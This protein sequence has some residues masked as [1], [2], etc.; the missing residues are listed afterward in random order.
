MVAI[1]SEWWLVPITADHCGHIPG[2]LVTMVHPCYT[3]YYGVA[4][5]HMMLSTQYLK[6]EFVCD[7]STVHRV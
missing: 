6:A 1:F 5:D 4:K 2:I 3:D 7:G